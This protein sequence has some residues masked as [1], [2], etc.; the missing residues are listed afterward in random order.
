MNKLL[1]IAFTMIAAS[2]CAQPVA[3]NG[4]SQ[5]ADEAWRSSDAIS[6][7]DQSDFSA[8]IDRLHGIARASFHSDMRSSVPSVVT[9][10]HVAEGQ[11]VKKG[12]ILLTLSDGV[13]KA[14][15]KAAQAAANQESTVEAAKLLWQLAENQMK[16]LQQA[17]KERASTE[18]ELEEK[19]AEYEQSRATYFSTIEKVNAAKAKL[20]VA[21][22]ELEKFRLRAPFDG[23]V[24]QIDK[25]LGNP[26]DMSE[27]ALTIVD[28]RVLRVEI[29]MPLRLFRSIQVDTDYVMRAQQPVNRSLTAKARYVAPAVD[30]TSGTFRCVFEIDNRE[31]EL[32]SGFAVTFA[33]SPG[34]P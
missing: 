31:L 24:L 28:A 22:A 30:S 20:E 23:Q 6:G 5:K 3:F 27:K 9:E 12:D 13:A 15:V 4:R 10:V 29:F 14:N 26:V 18:F 2:A 21:Q 32:P 11:W 34:K 7:G 25:G 19:N 17:Y 33:G 16:R 8:S 1:A